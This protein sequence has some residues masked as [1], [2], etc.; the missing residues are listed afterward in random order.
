MVCFQIEGSTQCDRSLCES[1]TGFDLD[2]NEDR[3]APLNVV[4]A[5]CQQPKD[6]SCRADPWAQLWADLTEVE[7]LA[8]ITGV[9]MGFG[10]SR[11]MRAEALFFKAKKHHY[12]NLFT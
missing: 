5:P 3:C 1:E 2:V 7:T 4:Q 10:V 8:A 6:C 11:G 9:I 12:H